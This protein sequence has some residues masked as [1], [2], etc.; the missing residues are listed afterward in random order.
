MSAMRRL[1]PLAFGSLVLLGGCSDSPASN[2][3]STEATAAAW[4]A[5]GRVAFTEQVEAGKAALKLFEPSSGS[6]SVVTEVLGTVTFLDADD[7]DRILL[8]GIGGA[9]TIL[10][11]NGTVLYTVPFVP[12]AM[13]GWV[14]LHL[15]ASGTL[16][17]LVTHPPMPDLQV[18]RADTAATLQNHVDFEGTAQVREIDWSPDDAFLYYLLGDPTGTQP[19]RIMKVETGNL[20]SRSTVFQD[21]AIPFLD[22]I[23]VSNDGQTLIVSGEDDAGDTGVWTLPAAGGTPTRVATEDGKRLTVRAASAPSPDGLR[24]VLFS[25]TARGTLL[26]VERL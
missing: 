22:R 14:A 11:Q 5:N 15:S 12:D 6:S 19:D 26:T 13:D 7:T 24:Y 3:I 25:T 4:T 20:A 1:R 10:R 21:P 16:L 8:G 23:F 17:A 9:Y 2:V 18:H